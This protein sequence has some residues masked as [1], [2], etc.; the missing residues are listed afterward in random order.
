MDDYI[1][2]KTLDN[3]PR[4]LFWGVDEFLI[5]V[6]PIFLGVLLGSFLVMTLGPVLKT[7]YTKSTKRFARGALKHK[8]YW[9]LP[10]Q[11]FRGVGILK[12]IPPS[13]LRDLVL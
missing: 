9:M 11:A 4:V 10:R 1:V 3:T 2:I 6:V 13:H 5:L 12:K 7:L 8:L